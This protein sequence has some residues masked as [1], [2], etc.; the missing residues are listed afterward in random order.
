MLSPFLIALALITGTLA[1]ENQAPKKTEAVVAPAETVM[2]TGRVVYED[3]GQP[4][5]RHRVQLIL[6]TALLNARRLR[7]PTAM[8]DERGEFTLRAVNAGDYYVFSEP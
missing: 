1:Q 7:I 2:V 4:A 5:T 6:A 3:T 8:T